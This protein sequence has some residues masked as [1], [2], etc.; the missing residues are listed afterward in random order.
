M[1]NINIPISFDVHTGN[2]YWVIYMNTIVYYLNKDKASS[3]N[4]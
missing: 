3:I 1:F 2:Y 4:K